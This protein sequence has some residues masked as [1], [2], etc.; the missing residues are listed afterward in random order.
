M[1]ARKNWRQPRTRLERD[2]ELILAMWSISVCA[3]AGVEASQIV[4]R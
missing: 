3:D 2:A 4:G 1:L